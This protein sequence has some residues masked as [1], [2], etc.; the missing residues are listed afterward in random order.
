MAQKLSRWKNI[1]LVQFCFNQSTDLG[2]L[3]G[4]YEYAV[5]LLALEVHDAL[6]GAVV[7]AV[8]RVERH[9][10]PHARRE[11]GR[12]AEAEG[13]Q[14]GSTHEDAIADLE[15]KK[16]IYELWIFSTPE[17]TKKGRECINTKV[18]GRNPALFVFSI[19]FSRPTYN[20]APCLKGRHDREHPTA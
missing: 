12:A 6:D 8:G 14:L 15:D 10:R 3:V 4:E 5:V 16:N 19:P 17:R 11:V 13:A 2:D 7:L 20:N 9:A 1:G 18:I